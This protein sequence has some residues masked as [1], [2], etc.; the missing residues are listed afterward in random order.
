MIL[1]VYKLNQVKSTNDI[2]INFIKNK[3]IKKGII[4][5]DTQSKGRATKGKKWISLKGNLFLSIFFPIKNIHP[6][7]YEF[8]IINPV[9]IISV[10]GKYYKKRNLQIKWPND[11]LIG[12]KKVCG[13]L[14]EIINFKEKS[15]MIIGIGVNLNSNPSIKNKLTTSIYLETKKLVNKNNF[16]KYIKEAY[17]NFFFD[18]ETYDFS[19]YNDKSK[20][21]SVN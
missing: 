9:L 18:L 20:S 10:I 1:R 8:A 7:F 2:A 3:G 14:Q 4:V 17:K 15:Y 5:T 6:K 11:I 16:L 19:F 13:I 12:N 21:L